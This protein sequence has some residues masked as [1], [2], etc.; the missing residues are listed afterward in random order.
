MADLLKLAG[1]LPGPVWT[2]HPRPG[3][4]LGDA[5]VR[6]GPN[7]GVAARLS[8]AQQFLIQ[9]M[10]SGMDLVKAVRLTLQVSAGTRVEAARDAEAAACCMSTLHIITWT[11]WP[12][13]RGGVPSCHQGVEKYGFLYHLPAVQLFNLQE[14]GQEAE[15][16][17]IQQPASQPCLMLGGS[18][19]QL[20]PRNSG[21]SQNPHQHLALGAGTLHQSH[22]RQT[23]NIDSLPSQPATAPPAANNGPWRMQGQQHE[24]PEVANSCAASG[25][26]MQ[27]EAVQPGQQLLL[28]SSHQAGATG[29]GGAGAHGGVGGTGG[30]GGSGPA[31]AA[32]GHQGQGGTVV[33][34]AG[35]SGTAVSATAA[36]GGSHNDVVSGAVGPQETNPQILARMLEEVNKAGV[37]SAGHNARNPHRETIYHVGWARTSANVNDSSVVLDL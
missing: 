27:C 5:P 6:V 1:P 32:A 19:H 21:P 13:L 12:S 18:A 9:H 37:F 4:Q 30:S 20:P 35:P 34:G 10:L 15:A 8:A 23:Q 17:A 2:S 33:G 24:S 7:P 31:H 36:S 22:G 3:A 25:G 14:F 28:P 16:P 11:W 26:H 29:Q